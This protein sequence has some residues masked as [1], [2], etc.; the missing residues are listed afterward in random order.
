MSR[1][2]T[3]RARARPHSRPALARRDARIDLSPVLSPDVVAALGRI[4]LF[5]RLA[6]DALRT[7][8]ARG[9]ARRFGAG[10]TL[11]LAGDEPRGLFVVIE[12]RVRVV[13]DADGRPF[14]VH[15][16]G[17]GGTLGEIPLFAG[18]SYPATAIAAEPT[19]CV[20]LGREA[21]GAAVAADPELAFRL[22][23][24]LSR[25]VR[26]LVERLESH[27]THSVERRTAALLLARAAEARAEGRDSFTLGATQG[28]AAAEV[29]TVREV[30]VRVLR[31]FRESGCVELVGR[32]RFRVA[33]E[34]A[35]R[36]VTG[37]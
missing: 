20:A 19:L 27:G 21:I 22:L 5:E 37:E 33:D 6:P 13:R 23:A 2:R 25:R 14:A 18:G 15:E 8:A 32:G 3:I 36:R 24:R 12:G 17:A 30:L 1:P 16:E 7:I 35:L 31:R 11:W 29:G 34:A 9:V 4:S 10:E 26:A 28:E